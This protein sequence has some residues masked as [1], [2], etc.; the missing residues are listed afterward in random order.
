MLVRRLRKELKMSMRRVVKRLVRSRT[1]LKK[2]LETSKTMLRSYTMTL[3]IR[4]VQPK[5]RLQTR[6]TTS[7]RAFVRL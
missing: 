5:M 3:L 1:T 7:R 6:P 4:Q 2:V